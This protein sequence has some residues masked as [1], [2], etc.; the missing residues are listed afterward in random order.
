MV[1][2]KEGN[3]DPENHRGGPIGA[4]YPERVAELEVPG[5]EPTAPLL[6]EPL[7]PFVA[8]RPSALASYLGVMS[9]PSP[10]IIGVLREV[11]DALPAPKGNLLSYVVREA[12]D[13]AGRLPAVAIEPQPPVGLIASCSKSMPES[14]QGLR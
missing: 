1:I 4:G 3:E 11:V 6:A 7:L 12:E 14:F 2:E 8:V 5:R 13:V 9:P 10:G